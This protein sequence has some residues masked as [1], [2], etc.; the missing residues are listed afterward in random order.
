MHLQFKTLQ[1]V[2]YVKHGI[3][4]FC[5]GNIFIVI[6]RLKTIGFVVEYRPF[7]VVIFQSCQAFNPVA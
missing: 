6:V 7:I 5:I 2:L 3:Q 1:Q 4:V